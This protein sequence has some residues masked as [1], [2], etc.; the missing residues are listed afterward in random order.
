MKQGLHK[1]IIKANIVYIT[2]LVG[3]TELDQLSFEVV[4]NLLTKM[5]D[6]RIEK[7]QALIIASPASPVDT[8]YCKFKK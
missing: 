2:A 6:A 4:A 1:A 8:F 3:S 7:T 5:Q